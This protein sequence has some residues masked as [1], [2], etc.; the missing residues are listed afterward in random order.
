MVKANEYNPNH[1]TYYTKESL[2]TFIEEAF[3]FYPDCRRIV[4]YL[5]FCSNSGKLIVKLNAI[6]IKTII[7]K[8][9][10][11]FIIHPSYYFQDS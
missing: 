10:D 6:T 9:I 4:K 5:Q 1:K 8:N 2:K 3:R 7:K 11:F